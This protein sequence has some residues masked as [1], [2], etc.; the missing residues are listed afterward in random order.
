MMDPAQRNSA[1]RFCLFLNERPIIISGLKTTLNKTCIVSQF[2]AVGNQLTRAHRHR[3]VKKGKSS[4][5]PLLKK[6]L[7]PEDRDR[8]KMCQ[9][10]DKKNSQHFPIFCE[11]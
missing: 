2:C 7:Q 11:F 5:G 8:G 9:K 1:L 6:Q 10:L 4:E 3:P